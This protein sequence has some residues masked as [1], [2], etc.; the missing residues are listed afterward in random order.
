MVNTVARIRIGS[1]HYEVAVDLDLA[2]K[3][4]KGV[5]GDVRSALLADEIFYNSKEGSKASKE[6]LETAFMT[7]DKLAV[8][9]RIIKKGDIELPQEHR[10][11]EAERRRKKVIDFFIRNAVDARTGRPYTSEMLNSAFT[12]AKINVTNKPIDEQIKSITEAL[13]TV[14]PIKI[15]TKKLIITLPAI[16]TGKAYGVVNEYKEKEEWLSDGSLKCTVNIPIGLQS[17]FYDKLNSITHGGAMTEEVK[18]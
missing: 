15:E 1:K 8:A 9:E 3:I 2:L 13:K 16:Y 5:G 17:E 14:I 7:S 10:D 18:Q 6:D 4:R 12:Q 11:E